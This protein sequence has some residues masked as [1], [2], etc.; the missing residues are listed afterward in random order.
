MTVRDHVRA[1]L[2]RIEAE[3]PRLNC[4]TRVDAQDALRAAEHAYPRHATGQTLSPLDGLTFAVKDNLAVQGKPWTAGMAGWRNRLAPHD[5][6]AV[7]RLREAGA[8][9]MGSLNMEEA[10]LG[11]VTDNP[12]FG[13]CY[14][15]LGEDLTPGGSSGGSG[16]AVAAGLV[17][18][19]L[20]TDTMG[21]V[22][23]P[24][25]YCGVAG[26]K[27]TYGWIDRDGLALLCPSLD[28]I[29]PIARDVSLLWPALQALASAEVPDDAK[30]GRIE[31]RSLAGATFGI[32]RQLAEVDCEPEILAG[33]EIARDAIETAGGTVTK[34]DLQGWNPGKARRAGLLLT[35]AEGA[36]ELADLMTQ[37]GAI[38]DHL[39]GLLEFGK[40]ASDEKLQG[41]R[42]EIAAAETSVVQA[43]GQ[44]NIILL[45]T[46]PQ[47]A[48]PHGTPAPANQADLTAL[49]NF[50]GCP[51][52]SIPVPLSGETLPA[53]VQLMTP[54]WHDANALSWAELL[55]E[56][57]KEP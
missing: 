40:N 51:A 31:R 42:A 48:F 32:P 39:R 27:P 57:L 45:P 50:A 56:A 29:G 20:G 11:A 44:T 5:S 41:A 38:S 30:R 21:S 17:D 14:N 52:V 8:I 10:A 25:A 1:A 35:E 43:W 46:T 16:A 28:T 6:I 19:A 12:H 36:I 24:A 55:S 3:N 47:R 26:I 22:R 33:L 34:I 13:R 54:K 49:A 9:L 18:L 2:G 4:F 23:V 53:S 37:P 7:A 15:P